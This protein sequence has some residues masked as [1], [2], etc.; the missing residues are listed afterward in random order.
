MTHVWGHTSKRWLAVLMGQV[1]CT[2]PTLALHLTEGVEASCV[3]SKYRV[4]RLASG[5]QPVPLLVMACNNLIESRKLR[6]P[7]EGPAVWHL[8][9]ISGNYV[10]L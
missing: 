7:D 6:S 8:V 5:Q 3:A 10:E 2:L 1:Q 4:L 9:A